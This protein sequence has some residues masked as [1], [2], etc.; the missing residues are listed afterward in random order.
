MTIA[1]ISG[2]LRATS[3]NTGLIRAAAD[4][5]SGTAEVTNIDWRDVPVYNQDDES[6]GEPPSVARIRQELLDADAI[7]IATPEYN[8]SYPGGLKNLLDWMSRTPRKPFNEKPVLVIGASTGNYGTVRAQ[9]AL[10]A[11]LS[12]MNAHTLNKPELLVTQAKAK[13]DAEGT[14]TDESTRT[15]FA[16]IL[17][18]FVAWSDRINAPTHP[19]A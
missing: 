15:V 17:S 2:S 16:G 12:H 8:Y 1:G 3:F 14:L 10:R 9:M 7:I 11:V 13:F 6:S 5:L 18:T 19:L 4:I